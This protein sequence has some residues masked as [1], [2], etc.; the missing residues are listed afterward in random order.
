MGPT[1][2]L[3]LRRKWCSG[4]LSPFK[5]H[6][7]RSG[8]NPRTLGPVASTLTTSPPRSTWWCHKHYVFIRRSPVRAGILG[9]RGS[10]IDDSSL[11]CDATVLVDSWR[12]SKCIPLKRWETAHPASQYH[13]PDNWHRRHC[14]ENLKTYKTNV[15]HNGIFDC[16]IWYRIDNQNS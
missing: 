7:P 6:R 3:P 11:E 9:F 15:S 5:I 4:F 14:N 2:L 13:I 12:W 8:S 1:A 16:S 10:V